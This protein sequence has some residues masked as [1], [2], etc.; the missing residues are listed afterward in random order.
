MSDSD[1]PFA[2]LS[3]D[4]GSSSGGDDP[5]TFQKR[6]FQKKKETTSPTKVGRKRKSVCVSDKAFAKLERRQEKASGSLQR[7]LLARVNDDDDDSDVEV[8]DDTTKKPDAAAVDVKPKPNGAALELSSDDDD[9]DN[10]P[11]LP[12]TTTAPA[13]PTDL[14][15]CKKLFE[16]KQARMQLTMAQQYHAEDVYV[17]EAVIDLDSSTSSSSV[18]TAEG[19]AVRRPADLGPEIQ[20]ALRTS[21]LVQGKRNVVSNDSMIIRQ[22][23]P[24]QALLGRYR[25]EKG[26][27]A[28]TRVRFSFDGQNVPWSK[29]PAALDMEAGDLV[30]VLVEGSLGLVNAASAP[31]T[32]V[33]SKVNLGPTITLKLRTQERGTNNKGVTQ[34]VLTI[35]EQEPLEK[36]LEKYKKSKSLNGSA[37]VRF[38]FDGEDI[39]LKKTPKSYDMENEDIIDVT[40]SR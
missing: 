30:D 6:K 16:A 32:V 9:D 24:F 26:V 10:V 12:S 33:K 5:F 38:E 4:D 39:D 8:V 13:R 15:M 35:R 7:N 20:L 29:T 18:P 25:V 23:E 17:P 3:G 1:D 31:K 40:L 22:R 34:D 36:L 11:A 2:D 28:S 14:A 27:A 19:A 37:R 21:Q